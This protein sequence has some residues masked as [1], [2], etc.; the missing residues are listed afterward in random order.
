MKWT[1][2][3]ERTLLESI[4]R[5]LARRHAFAAERVGF[6]LTKLGNRSSLSEQLVLAKEYWPV[7]DADY[8]DDPTVGARYRASVHRHLFERAMEESV[9]VFHVHAHEHSGVPGFS[10]VDLGCIRKLVPSLRTVQSAE[11]HGGVLLSNDSVTGLCWLPAS[12]TPAG[13]GRVV[14]VGRP[15]EVFPVGVSH[16]R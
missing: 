11:G 10:G 15:L 6:L 1:F 7:P 9:G 8:I 13:P 2:R 4:R 5:D 14:V 16:V 12:P 3:I